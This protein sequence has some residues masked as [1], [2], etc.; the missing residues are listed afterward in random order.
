MNILYTLNSGSPGGMEQHVLDLV[1]GM[2]KKGDEV[3]VWCSEGEI[4]KWYQDAGAV[5]TSKRIRFE[6]DPIY[7]KGLVNFIKKNNINV[8][9]AHGLKACASSMLASFFAKT[10]VTVTHIHTPISEWQIP[11][12]PKK[13]FTFFEILGYSLEVNLFSDT[14]IALTESRR[15]VKVGEGIINSKLTVI[16]NGL[17]LSRF[18]VS[19]EGK[20]QDRS[21]IREKYGISLEK[22]VIGNVSRM[23]D[24]KGHE[25]LVEA[26]SE[27]VKTAKTPEKY[28][29]LLAGGGV[30]EEKI[31]KRI[32]E[33][34]LEEYVTITGIFDAAELPQFYNAFDLFVFPTLAEGFGIV[35]IEGMYSEVPVV[36]SNLA[37][38]EE[39]GGDTITFFNKG[40]VTD[41]TEKMIAFAKEPQKSRELTKRAKK[42]V[43]ML[44]TLDVFVENYYNLYTKLLEKNK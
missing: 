9:H 38:L 7:I 2:K 1:K 37:V 30:L 22:V 3:F 6:L 16:P 44:Y 26:F 23:T 21:F 29:L 39:V 13:I 36:C 34:N 41:L 12:L 31:S 17:D 14:E 35:L 42:R 15:K 11:N 20:L 24:E 43:S 5:V 40:D 18:E 32:S 33:L 27:F 10:S 4:V 19:R 25:I 8:V 28:H